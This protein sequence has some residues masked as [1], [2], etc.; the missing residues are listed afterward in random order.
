MRYVLFGEWLWC[1]HAV[2]YDALPSYFLG[3]DL[4]EKE[5]GKFLSYEK[6]LERVAGKIKVVP[7]VWSGNGRDKEFQKSISEEVLKRNSN[8]GSEQ[9]EGVYI[10]LEADGYVVDRFK[11]RRKT[12]N[13]GRDSFTTHIVNNQIKEE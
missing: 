12:F 11:L 3:F 1:K 10:R 4:M 2:Q 8:H 6:F 13:S 9:A 5:T 7:L